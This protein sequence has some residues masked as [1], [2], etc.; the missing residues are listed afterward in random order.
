MAFIRVVSS[1]EIMTPG[2]YLS[3]WM[4][5]PAAEKRMLQKRLV[6]LQKTLNKLNSE[7][8]NTEQRIAE[9][10]KVLESDPKIGG[11]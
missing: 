9:L 2:Y 11:G 7:F 6:A 10:D 8:R 4:Y 3:A 1:K 5:M